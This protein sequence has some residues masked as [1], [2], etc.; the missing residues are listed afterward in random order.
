MTQ[1]TTWVA[2]EY[3]KVNSP[4]VKTALA[5]LALV[6]DSLE[7]GGTFAEVGCGA[8][9]IA[10]TFAERGF[11]VWA[12]DASPSMVETTRSQCAGLPVRAEVRRVEEL[13]LPEG[14]FD[15]VHSSWVLHWVSEAE[16]PL[17]R[18]ARALRPGGHLVLQWTGAQPRDEGP[19]LFGI[20]RRIAEEPQW[21]ELFAAVPPAMRD[22]PA[23]LVAEVLTGAGLELV[24]YVPELPHPFSRK[25]GE[26]LTPE[27]LA[28]MRVR[29]KR[30][31]F[32]SQTELLGDRVDEFLDEALG[33]LV[34]AGRT[35]PHHARI[36]ARRPL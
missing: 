13:A 18:L 1:T 32:A 2:D 27:E 33:A 15:V 8:G 23:D 3:V 26:P 36:V 17:R 11:E 9:E 31:W 28:E 16:E 29:F 22:Y 30:T 21:R 6:G 14:Q 10:R 24:H 25:N 35:D 12:S 5:A 19:G 20:L 4:H 34:A 7:R